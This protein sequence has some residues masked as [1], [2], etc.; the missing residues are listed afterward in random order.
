MGQRLLTLRV[1]PPRLVVLID[2]AGPAADF[3]AAVRFLSQVWGGRYN[4]II[5]V[6]RDLSDALTE[7]QLQQL[8]PDFVFG[9]NLDDK[10]W[11]SIVQQACQPRRYVPL[12]PTMIEDVSSDHYLYLIHSDRAVIA[13]FV[14]RSKLSALFRPVVAVTVDSAS[15]WAPFVAALFGI[16]RPNLSEKYRDEQLTQTISSSADLI[17]LHCDFVNNWKESWLDAGSFGLSKMDLELEPAIEPTIVIVRNVIVDLCHFWNL[18]IGC[19]S[20]IPQWLL[21]IPAEQIRSLEVQNLLKVWILAFAKYGAHPNYLQVTSASVPKQEVEDIAFDLKNVMKDSAIQFVD[22]EPR[23]N[24]IRRVVAFEHTSIWPADIQRR[25]MTMVPPAPK[26][27]TISGR[28]AWFVDIVDDAKTGRSI[29]EMQLPENPIVLEL[30]NG[31]C[32]PNFEHSTIPRFGDG[33]NSINFRCTAG[34]EIVRFHIPSPTE[35]LEEILRE[36]GY[37]IVSDEKRSSYLPT[38]RHFGGLLMAAKAFSG[39]SG[40]VLEILRSGRLKSNTDSSGDKT[41]QALLEA[42][43]HVLLPDKIKKIGRFGNGRLTDNHYHDQINLMLRSESDRTKRIGEKRYREF[44]SRQVPD[45]M[46][47]DALL[48]HWA[49]KSVIRRQWRL[50][51]C[52]RC[53]RASYVGH[54]NLQHP[55]RCSYCG[56]RVPMMGPINIGYTL[57]RSVRHSLNEGLATVVLTGRFLRNMTNKGF[58]WLPGLKYKKRDVLGDI[59]ILASCDGSLVFGECKRLTNTSP[60]SKIWEQTTTQFLDLASVAIEC[61]GA[62]VVLAAQVDEFPSQ[63]QE[64]IERELA[65]RIPYLLLANSDLQKGHRPYPAGTNCSWLNLADLIPDPFPEEPYRRSPGVREINYKWSKFTKEY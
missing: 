8:R 45:D 14:A 53:N 36:Y 48:E 49:D 18:R 23:Q 11:T 65:G 6:S 31:P 40:E 16:H 39:Q 27:V 50:G 5:P 47:L 24:R 62:I 59:D 43:G 7:F 57:R 41:H 2:S 35:V 28:E 54:V 42:Q 3:L 51:P 29:K 33:P 32:P 20:H 60:D 46:T 1:R 25:S 38:I 21:P 61:K 12:T 17:R 58:F 15:D 10:V 30:L 44:A 64:R 19:D 9:L 22:Y 56:N 37:E 13:K 55:V 34:K 26:S 63:V 52:S 4:P